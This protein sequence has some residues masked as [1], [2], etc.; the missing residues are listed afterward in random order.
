ML[1]NGQPKHDEEALL[2]RLP[3][4]KGQ[5]A[6]RSPA[7]AGARS[8]EAATGW[9]TCCLSMLFSDILTS[10]PGLEQIGPCE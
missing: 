7:W 6:P 3:A 9:G 4:S 8:P 10:M 2:P 5:A 1:I